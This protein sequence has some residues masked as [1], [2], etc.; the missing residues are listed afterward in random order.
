MTRVTNLRAALAHLPHTPSCGVFLYLLVGS[1][2]C[3]GN[4]RGFE[5]GVSKLV[6]R[7]GEGI[8]F[9]N[10][11]HRVCLTSLAVSTVFVWLYLRF[12]LCLLDFTCG[13][14]R[15]CLTL[16]AVST[17]FVWYNH[18]PGALSFCDVCVLVRVL[19]WDSVVLYSFSAIL[20][21]FWLKSLC[22]HCVL[23]A[24]S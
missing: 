11:F 10:G 17:V 21:Y 7:A 12:P 23:A 4:A 3:G 9:G 8:F 16:L 6:Y 14:H 5:E 20:C 18:F 13:F 1:T 15:V 24:Q 22:P 19:F 2:G